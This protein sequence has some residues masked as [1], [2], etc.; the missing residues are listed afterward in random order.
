M[1]RRLYD[2]TY[3]LSQHPHAFWA[4]FFI[5]FIESSVFPI[6][7][8]ILLIPIIFANR[9]QAFKLALICTIG[10]TF[11][12]VFGYSIGYFFFEQI[13]MPI[14][15][16]YG[17]TNALQTFS[18]QFNEWGVWIVAAAGFT[19]LPYKII[20]ITS[21]VTHLNFGIFLIT[22]ILSRGARFFLIALVL[23]YCGAKIEQILEKHLNLIT[24][25]IFTLLIGGFVVA[26]Y[27]FGGPK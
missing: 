6:P 16:L 25:A 20:T 22:S 12:G 27:L 8:D 24:T 2:W 10:S 11:G 7:P 18:E 3:S 19:P 4:L 15:E 26:Y 13:G 14:V 9:S 17:Y 23:K 21:G 1:I 5:A